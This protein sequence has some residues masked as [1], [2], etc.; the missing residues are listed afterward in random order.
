MFLVVAGDEKG[1][2]GR[3]RNGEWRIQNGEKR[4]MR[5]V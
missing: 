4:R 3:R 1:D 5:R 2:E